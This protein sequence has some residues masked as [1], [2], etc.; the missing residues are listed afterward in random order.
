VPGSRW[1]RA[2]LH[3]H[4]LDDH[5]NANLTRPSE[6]AY[7]AYGGDSNHNPAADFNT[8]GWIDAMDRLVLVENFGI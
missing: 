1:F 6:L 5:P 8:D 7:G 2:D 4:T 3:P